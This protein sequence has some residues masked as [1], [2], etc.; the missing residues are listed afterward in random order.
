MRIVAK[1]VVANCCCIRRDQT[2]KVLPVPSPQEV[3]V[4]VESESLAA[5]PL[6]D[7]PALAVL[8]R[9]G[10]GSPAGRPAQEHLCSCLCLSWK[11][12]TQVSEQE[13]DSSVPAKC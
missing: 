4:G 2:R 3:S 13:L 7:G 5:A 11:G 9:G 10:E 12:D 6:R 1:P 8:D